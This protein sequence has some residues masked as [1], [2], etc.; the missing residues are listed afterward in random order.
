MKDVTCYVKI[1][2][3]CNELDRDYSRNSNESWTLKSPRK[4][5][6][7][8]TRN[9]L[10]S[11]RSLFEMHYCHSR[12]MARAVFN[13]FEWGKVY[14]FE[15]IKNLVSKKYPSLFPQTEARWSLTW[16]NDLRCFVG[17]MVRLNILRQ[18]GSN[19]IYNDIDDFSELKNIYQQTE[20]NN[21]ID[22]CVTVE[23]LP[24]QKF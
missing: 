12:P 20:Y 17:T 14:N 11:M 22:D 1:E 9:E 21:S 5:A 24:Y 4:N 23:Y 15:K 6:S 8:L 18:F 16:R 2:Q 19:V 3:R 13:V 10:L 7:P